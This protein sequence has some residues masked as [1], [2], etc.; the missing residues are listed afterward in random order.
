MIC[1]LC[2]LRPAWGRASRIGGRSGWKVEPDGRLRYIDAHPDNSL[3]RGTYDLRFVRSSP[4]MGAGFKNWRP[5]RLEHGHAVLA[6]NL[7]IADFSVSQFFGN[8]SRGAD[9][10]WKSGRFIL[11]GED[12]DYY[13]Y[14]RA[15]LA[16]D[17]LSFD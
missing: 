1:A 2:A 13:D 9:A 12:L 8:S 16:G 3:T 17:R 7:E 6:K 5:L 10:D 14:V 11:N 4:G 15:R